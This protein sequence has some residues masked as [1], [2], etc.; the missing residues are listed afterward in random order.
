VFN[1]YGRYP[2]LRGIKEELSEKSPGKM[3][4]IAIAIG[5]A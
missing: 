5:V 1:F 2:F 3:T 4:L